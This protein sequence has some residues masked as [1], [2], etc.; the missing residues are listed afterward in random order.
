MKNKETSIRINYKNDQ[1]S[2]TYNS[3][4]SGLLQ[5]LEFGSKDFSENP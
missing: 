1:V 5:I 2:K 3:Q 4:C